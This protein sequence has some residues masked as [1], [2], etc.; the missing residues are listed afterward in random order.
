MR[1]LSSTAPQNPPPCLEVGG[2]GWPR[3]P[4][5]VA[6][7][8]KGATLYASKSLT[9]SFW[10][11]VFNMDM[12]SSTFLPKLEKSSFEFPLTIEDRKVRNKHGPKA[13]E[14]RHNKLH[15]ATNQTAHQ[16]E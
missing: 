15:N 6:V 8:I 4:G 9:F 3:A 12:L 14:Y 1:F 10:I 11:L 5:S 7:R 13:P 2:W 16:E